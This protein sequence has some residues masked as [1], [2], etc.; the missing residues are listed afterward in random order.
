[1]F[2][3]ELESKYSGAYTEELAI[4]KKNLGELYYEMEEYERSREALAEAISLFDSI[5]EKS[6]RIIELQTMA[7]ELFGGG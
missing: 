2:L 1:M 5:Q 6:E 7:S 3:R 4:V